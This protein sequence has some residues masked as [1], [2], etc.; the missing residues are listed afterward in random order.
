MDEVNARKEKNI[1]LP[2]YI[3]ITIVLGGIGIYGFYINWKANQPVL[4][5]LSAILVAAHLG[6]YWLNLRQFHHLRWWVFYYSAQTVLIVVIANLPYSGEANL[7]GISFLGSATIAI[8]GE[9]LGLWGNTRRAFFLG[10]FYLS[11]LLGIFSTKVEPDLILPYLT[12]LLIIGGF[13]VIL[14][15][16][17]NLQIKERQ[18][19][20]ELAETLESAN[21]KL[22]TYAA[23]NESLTLQAERERMARELHDTLAQGVAGLILQ[24]EALKEHQQQNRYPQAQSVLEQAIARARSTLGESRAAIENLRNDKVDFKGVVEALVAQFKSVS[25]VDCQLTLQLNENSP[26]PQNIQ[27]HA[28]RVLHEAL[29]NINKH[30]GLAQAQINIEQNQSTLSLHITDDGTGFDTNQ[31]YAQGCFGLQGLAERARLTHSQYMLT[32]TPGAGTTIEF[33]FPLEGETL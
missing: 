14:M 10:L 18:K 29:A 17:F 19:A 27:H 11:I 33:I 2:F 20:E 8:T 5:A 23:R 12:Q 13:I 32:S 15:V 28:Q 4:A 25:E 16:V 22:A 21:A 31:P 6:L 3:F 30:A 26:I 1:Y 7:F 24:L 9:V